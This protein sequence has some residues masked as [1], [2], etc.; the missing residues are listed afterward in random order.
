MS[1]NYL[2]PVVTSDYDLKRAIAAAGD[3][4]V[5]Y[6]P[7]EKCRV[8]QPSLDIVIQL[9]RKGDM[10]ILAKRL[11]HAD[12]SKIVGHLVF[13]SNAPDIC[14]T[15]GDDWIYGF[16]LPIPLTLARARTIAHL[17]QV[18]IA[19]GLGTPAGKIDGEDVV[20]R[21]KNRIEMF[22]AI[23]EGRMVADVS[24]PSN[25]LPDRVV[26]DRVGQRI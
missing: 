23:E 3:F 12:P 20:D 13:D 4:H 11:E 6:P 16:D 26:P 7:Y 9:L 17:E 21:F 18:C 10:P 15:I 14:V 24:D 19:R 2:I 22:L 5:D 25:R 8:F 1:L